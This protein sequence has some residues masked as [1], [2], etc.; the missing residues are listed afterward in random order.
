MLEHKLELEPEWHSME[1]EQQ[2]IQELERKLQV[3]VQHS[4]EP[5]LEQGQHSKVPVPERKQVL[6]QH[7]MVQAPVLDKPEHILVP[8]LGSKLEPELVQHSKLELV[9]NS[10]LVQVQHSDEALE[11]IACYMRRELLAL[12]AIHSLI[13]CSSHC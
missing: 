5:V 9:Q 8:E 2:R 11:H 4:M 6:E 12:K 13:S 1:L 3:L 7:S 10:T